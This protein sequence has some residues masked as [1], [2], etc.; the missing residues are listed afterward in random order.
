M[1]GDTPTSL[2]TFG[3]AVARLAARL[4]YDPPNLLGLHWVFDLRGCNSARLTAEGVREALIE[5]P[6]LL[7]LNTVGMPQLW[8][9]DAPGAMRRS[10]ASFSFERAT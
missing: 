3:T 7:S 1:V 2:T 8:E 10:R 5:V 9:H 6:R 4:G